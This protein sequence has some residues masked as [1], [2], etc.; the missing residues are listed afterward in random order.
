MSWVDISLI[1]INTEDI[2]SQGS[3][4]KYPILKNV[5]KLV[6]VI[7]LEFVLCRIVSLFTRFSITNSRSRSVPCNT[8]VERAKQKEY[9]LIIIVHLQVRGCDKGLFKK[10]H[11]NDITSAVCLIRINYSYRAFIIYH[12]VIISNGPLHEL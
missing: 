2:N 1:M 7:I 4:L 6:K 11:D 9:I 10:L 8:T 3:S 12:F 5:S